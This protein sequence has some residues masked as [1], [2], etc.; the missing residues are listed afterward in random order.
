M[1]AEQMAWEMAQTLNRPDEDDLFAYPDEYFRALSKSHRYF[2]RLFAAHRPQ[3]I[4][5]NTTLTSS[6]GGNTFTLPDDHYG[7]MLLFG[8]PGPPQGRVFV[9]SDPESNGHYWQEGR[10]IR[11]LT[12]YPDTLYV[13]W[14]PATVAD[15]SNDEDSTLPSYC[16][17]AIIQRACYYL[18][19]KPGF[20]GNPEV[21]KANSEEEW[22]GDP[23]NPADMGVLGIISRQSAHQ[24]WEGSGDTESPWWRFNR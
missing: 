1:N 5:S 12:P 20:L 21:Y 22:G 19:Q 24:A 10:E 8:S 7:E 15:I 9:P 13:R 3:L 18:A 14:V 23:N 4:Y 16:D 17:D 2:R 11:M 6:D